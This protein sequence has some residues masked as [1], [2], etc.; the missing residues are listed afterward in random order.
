LSENP[1]L[2]HA[3]LRAL[4]ALMLACKARDR[5]QAR[6]AARGHSAVPA[7]EALLAATSIHLAEGDLLAPEPVD[8]A[9]TELAPAAKDDRHSASL[10]FPAEAGSRLALCAAAARGIQATAATGESGI[11]LAYARAGVHEPGWTEA[12]AWAHREQLP[13]L[14]ACADPT[15]GRT[16]KA[17]LKPGQSPRLDWETISRLSRSTKLP[18]L[19]V[20]GED[21]VAIY[22]VMQESVLRARIGGGPAVIWAIMTP[23]KQSLLRSAEPVARLRSY[24][25][26]RKIPLK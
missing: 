26:T 1:L 24:M 2:P 4:Y 7:R 25:A 12:L 23:A 6:H 3:Q 19:S 21:A 9:A 20:D 15:G 22:R 10:L 18:V 11:V 16:S 13:L 14:V 5:A 17:A 8:S